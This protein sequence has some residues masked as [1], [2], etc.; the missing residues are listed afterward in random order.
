MVPQQ[1][2]SGMPV[3]RYRPFP[4]ID[5]P[6]RTWPAKTI[7]SAP[8][9]LSTDLRDGNQALIEPMDP[10]RKHEIFALLVRMGY[11]EIE[12]GF[13]AASQTDF[14][15][16]RSLVENDLIP[17]DV[18]IS[19][20]TQA[21]PDLIERTV[22]S[23]VGAKRS[24]VH[25][26]NATAPEFRRVVFGVDREACKA[27]A[28]D[29][30]RTVV[31][32]IERYLGEAEYVGY[33]YSPEIFIDTELDFAL[34][35]CEAVMDVW[36]PGPGREIIL[37]LPATVE[38]ATPNVY[39]DQIEWMSR[40]LSRREHVCLSV[41]PHNDRG[42]GIASAELGVMA[43]ADRVEGCLYGHGERTGNVDLVTLGM[44]LFSQGVDPM[45]DF[46]DIDTVRRIVEHCTQMPVAPRHP[47]GGDLVYTAF[48]GSHQDAIKKGLTA[49]E[50][51]AAAA[52][53]PVAE[54]PWS[55]PYLPIDP[56]DVGRSYEAVIRV[57]SQS[58]KGGVSYILHR[59]HALDV[60][61]RMQI[62]FSHKVQEFTDTEG[63]EFD[64]ERL[65]EIFSQT[66][67]NDDGPVGVLAHRSET[68][69]DGGYRISADV[70]AHG[71]I[72][73]IAGAGQGPISA[74]CDALTDVDVKVRVLDYV[75]HSLDV[76]SDARAAAYVE[77]EID[78]RTVWGVGIH[79]NITTASLKAVCSAI[80]RAQAE[81][82]AE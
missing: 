8:R 56:K 72:R 77:T 69:A 13:P 31:D 17:D 71:E 62:E 6:D 37:N 73:E 41:H 10:Q 19:V 32:C 48:S 16:V 52:G 66:Y 36:R 26:Y 65:W 12:V 4:A 53:T 27:I 51:D 3:H 15:F 35:V 80:G 1:Q 50:A 40:N 43:G 79:H 44:N 39:A 76:G 78:G 21:R 20:L 63:G 70:R 45:I 75:E 22:Q 67:L 46:S 11:K 49:L 18:Q 61:R 54:Y 74:F 34:E 9:W 59:D 42:T 30:T 14:D 29:G 64:G 68:A 82:A 33:E 5:L 7:T 47:Y 57:N 24:T 23:L 28:A 81:A 60:P 2:P 25:L 58:G 38:R 55:V